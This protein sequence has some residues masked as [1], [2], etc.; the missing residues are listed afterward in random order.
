MIKLNLGISFIYIWAVRVKSVALSRYTS[1]YDEGWSRFLH[2]DKQYD[3]K[4]TIT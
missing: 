3:I 4:Q 1:N 2:L